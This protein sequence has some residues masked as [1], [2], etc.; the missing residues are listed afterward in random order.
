MRAAIANGQA[1]DATAA[2]KELK[3]AGHKIPADWA[4]RYEAVRRLQEV[5]D[6]LEALV[7]NGM[8]AKACLWCGMFGG[9]ARTGR[10]SDTRQAGVAWAGAAARPQ[11]IHAC[12]TRSCLT[13][14]ERVD[15]LPTR[16]HITG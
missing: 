14:I 5:V 9:V 13:C 4:P 11:R 12:I 7:Q 16:L 10:A 3:K 6:R 8:A 2:A 15:L 1:D